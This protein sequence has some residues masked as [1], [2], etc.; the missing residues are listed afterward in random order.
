MKKLIFP[1]ILC[2]YPYA[3][4][5]DVVHPHSNDEL[6]DAIKE[7]DIGRV[8][9]IV[10]SKARSFNKEELQHYLNELKTFVKKPVANLPWYQ[11]YDTLAK[12]GLGAF[13]TIMAGRFLSEAVELNPEPGVGFGDMIS[14]FFK[15]LPSG[16]PLLANAR[17][18]HA[19]LC[20]A[21][22]AVGAL[23]LRTV[24]TGI[25]ELFEYRNALKAHAIRALI[26]QG[27]KAI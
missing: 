5:N 6:I 7:L 15:A 11:R 10:E 4:S 18:V 9:H 22:G 2:L 14:R 26:K 20:M 1:L 23:S 19:P 13:G 25:K 16:S 3:Y 12:I 27:L 8:K 21:A 24:I 17:P